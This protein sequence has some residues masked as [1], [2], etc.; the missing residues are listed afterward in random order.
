MVVR[1]G[2]GDPSAL[3]AGVDTPPSAARPVINPASTMRAARWNAPRRTPPSLHSAGPCVRAMFHTLCHRCSGHRPN[4]L[5]TVR[6]DRHR[7]VRAT[8]DPDQRS[9]TELVRGRSAGAESRLTSRE[10]EVVA[11]PG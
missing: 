5:R 11:C 4:L 2:T 7:V 3:A 9:V 1:G 6:T 10:L 8:T